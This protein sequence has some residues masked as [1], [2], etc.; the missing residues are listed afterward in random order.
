MD[1]A[2]LRV[3]SSQLTALADDLDDMR[4]HLNMQIRRMDAIV[5]TIEAGWGGQTAKAY[6]KLHHGAAEDAVR[7]REVIKILGQA[8]R[9]SRDGF[10]EQE[11][12]LLDQF[13]RTQSSVDVAAEAGK[14]STPNPDSAQ[15]QP[16]R[17]SGLSDL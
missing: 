15:Q 14:L 10:T 9:L 12:D 3:T 16:N 2:D 6:R 8:V 7:I 4:D 1:P 5:D 11:L 13:R 17:R